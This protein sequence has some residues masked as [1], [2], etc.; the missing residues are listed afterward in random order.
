MYKMYVHRYKKAATGSNWTRCEISHGSLKRVLQLPNSIGSRFSLCAGC[1]C[2]AVETPDITHELILLTLFNGLR[3]NK[4]NLRTFSLDT[5]THVFLS[6]STQLFIFHHIPN[7][8]RWNQSKPDLFVIYTLVI[9]LLVC[10][11]QVLI[12]VLPYCKRFLNPQQK[13]LQI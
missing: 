7:T 12:T 10:Y 6:T 9:F 3:T 4:V 5:T 2:W 13:R 11:S 1:C 8:W